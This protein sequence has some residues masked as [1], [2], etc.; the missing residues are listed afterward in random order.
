MG[1][2]LDLDNVRLDQY[3]NK[4]DSFDFIIGKLLESVILGK[5]IILSK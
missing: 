3:A 4:A 2:Q 5:G 1:V